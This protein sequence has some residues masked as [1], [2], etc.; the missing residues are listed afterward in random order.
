MTDE[1]TGADTAPDISSE[2]AAPAAD[3]A[4]P[5][6]RRGG[7]AS[8]FAGG[9]V[10]GLLVSALAL[11]AAGAL[12]P[13]LRPRLLG[14]DPDQL[15]SRTASMGR[16]LALMQGV[17]SS[18]GQQE[19]GGD[20]LEGR[21]Q[22]LE[23]KLADPAA[24]PRLAPL[25]RSVE[26]TRAETGTLKN[27]VAALRDAIPPAGTI[28]RLAERAD[29]AE[30]VAKEIASRHAQTQALLLVVGQLRD[31]VDRGDPYDME[32]QAARRVAAADLSPLLD[33][34]AATAATGLPRRATL[35]DS[36]AVLAPAI[37]N[38]GLAPDSGDLWHRAL[39][40]LAG[41]IT[42]RRIDG[43]G[44]DTAAVLA[45]A[46]RDL[47][48]NALEKAVQDLQ[49]LQGAPAAVAAPWLRDAKARLAADK[50]LSQL[51]AAAIAKTAQPGG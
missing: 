1:R 40:K 11:G 15:Q 12:W 32:L 18:R 34:L 8:G 3:S 33:S 7:F 29:A 25:A 26:E 46:E 10:G 44:N 22:A 28:L 2:T 45:R 17:L 24:D 47:H 5:A 43:I 30:K 37:Y 41:M 49:P 14:F 35:L 31:A 21:V 36:F 6:R 50:A 38:A 13:Q 39:H 27:D 19:A 23:Q 20:G 16:T 9:L 4:G 48:A 42:I 51:T